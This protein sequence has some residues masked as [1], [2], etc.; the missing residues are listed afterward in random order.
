MLGV[1]QIA[2]AFGA[3]VEA[4]VGEEAEPGAGAEGVAVEERFAF[5]NDPE[6]QAIPF[7]GTATKYLPLGFVKT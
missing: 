1:A 4:T 3:G 2:Y 7:H 5:L 6:L